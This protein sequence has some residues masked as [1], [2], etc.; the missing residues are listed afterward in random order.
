MVEK[1]SS[2]LYNGIENL[3]TNRRVGT[4]VLKFYSGACI[5]KSSIVIDIFKNV[6]AQRA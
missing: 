1:S 6:E 5:S 2:V 4:K 3:G